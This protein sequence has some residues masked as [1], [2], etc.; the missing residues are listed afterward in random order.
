MK[1]K[2]L[3]LDDRPREKML[4]RGAQSLSDSELIAILLRTG[5]KGESAIQLAQNMLNKFGN[6]A[7]LANQSISTIAQIKGIGKNKAASL[8]AAFEI[9]R[10]VSSG[11]KWF[12]K[13]KITS[14]KEAADIFIPIFRDEVKEHFVVICLNNSNKIIRYE[15]LTTGTLN[16]SLVHAREVFKTAFEHNSANIILLHNHPSGNPEPSNEDKAITKR[17]VEIGKLMEVNIFDHI[18]V[19]GNEYFSFVE[20][21]LI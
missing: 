3:P 10:R 15:I 9:S 14:P 5:T 16:A 8:F 2:D 21:K 20:K 11:Y 17:L 7:L 4:I 19:A 6:L 18:I 12:S 13:N 1:V